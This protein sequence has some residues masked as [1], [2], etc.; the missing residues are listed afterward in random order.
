LE[1]PDR[2]RFAAAGLEVAARRGRRG[3]LVIGAIDETGQEKAGQATD[4]Q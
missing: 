4:L 2:S 3:R 1:R